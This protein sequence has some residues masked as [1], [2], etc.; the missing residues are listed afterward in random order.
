M[1]II[2]HRG[3]RGLAPENTLVALEKAIDYD[4]DEVEFDVR[5]TSDN[6]V[7]LH[8]DKALMDASG[9]LFDIDQHSLAE[10]RL[11][12]PD[13][14]LLMDAITT[15]NHR[16]PMLIEIKPGV[17]IKPV[18]AVIKTCLQVGWQPQEMIFGSFSYKIL[19]Q[20]HTTLPEIPTVVIERWSG[21]RAQYRARQLNTKLISINQRWLWWGFIRAMSSSGYDLYAYTLNDPVKA[22]RWA[23]YG[24]AGVVTD[25]PDLFHP[26]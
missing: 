3:A 7:V 16:V 17:N 13:L 19:R 4:V 11:H 20:L 10:L 26:K 23:K 18:I 2:G 1:K 15:I 12:K 14:A 5:V 25:Y 22:R 21:I 24:L 6:V 9:A 8:H